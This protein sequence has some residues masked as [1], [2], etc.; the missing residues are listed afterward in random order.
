MYSINGESREFYSHVY[1]FH[2][3]YEAGDS[4]TLYISKDNPE[5]GL[6][7][8]FSDRWF[9]IFLSLVVAFVLFILAGTLL[10]VKWEFV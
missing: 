1:E 2:K 6:L 7:D 3:S 5:V 8:S 9:S 4:L 10:L